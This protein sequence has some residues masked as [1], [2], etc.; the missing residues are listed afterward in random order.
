MNRHVDK[1]NPPEKELFDSYL[2]GFCSPE[3]GSGC[4]FEEH[5][6]DS[7]HDTKEL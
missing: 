6:E 3:F 2:N 1:N 7:P 5:E 4:L